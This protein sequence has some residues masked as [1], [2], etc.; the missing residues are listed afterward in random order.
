M[1]TVKEKNL[2]TDLSFHAIAF[3]IVSFNCYLIIIPLGKLSKNST[4]PL[5]HKV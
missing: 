3:R 1:P 2:S 5:S 4:I